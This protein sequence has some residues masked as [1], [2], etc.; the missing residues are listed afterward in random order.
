VTSWT[1]YPELL[2]T[3][4]PRYTSY[5]TAAEISDQVGAR[6]LES[7]L[8]AI[9]PDQPISLYVHIPYCHEICWYCGCNTGAANKAQR[10]AGYLD[11]LHSELGL[12]SAKLA[13]RGRVGRIAFGGGSPNAISPE[14]FA[15]LLASLRTAFLADNALLSIELDPRSL[16]GP[17]FESI[18]AAGIERAS[19]GVQTFDPKVQR[20]IG[21]IQR[22]SLIRTA[23]DELRRVGVRSLNFDLMYGLPYQGLAE[24]EATLE[25]TI[26]MRPERIALFGYAHVPHLIPRQRRIDG[27]ALPEAELRFA[28]AELGHRLL[29]HAGYDPIGFDHYARPHDPLSLAAR[30]GRLRRN[31]QGFTDDCAEVLIGLGASAISQ[32]PGLIAQ[33][34]KNAGRYKIR[35]SS[36]LLPATHGIIRDADDRRRGRVIEQLL[37]NGEAEVR[38]YFQPELMERLQPFLDC[39]LATVERGRLRLPDYARPYARVIAS[40]FDHHRQPAARRFSSAI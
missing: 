38:E 11:A 14:Q 30:Q 25:A 40:L 15:E 8:A 28:Q 35:L 3:P 24:L 16:S 27:S 13:G 7:A 31:F 19:L 21:R 9:E 37:C 22:E 32:V 36:G 12:V 2:A 20:S 23:V 33:N 34:E 29:S 1:Y 10:L 5:P 17:W 18:G 26:E 39:G 4:V 6:E